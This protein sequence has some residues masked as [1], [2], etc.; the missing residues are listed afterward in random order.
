MK[1]A[2]PGARQPAIQQV[3]IEMV[4]GR[5]IGPERF[6]N[7]GDRL[8]AKNRGPGQ[9]LIQQQQIDADVRSDIKNDVTVGHRDAMPPVDALD[10][11]L[12]IEERRVISA[13]TKDVELV[14]KSISGSHAISVCH[15]AIIR[16]GRLGAPHYFQW[17]SRCRE[18]PPCRSRLAGCRWDSGTPRSAFPT[19]GAADGT[20]R[21]PAALLLLC[22]LS[23]GSHGY[24]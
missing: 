22:R 23:P 16:D 8:E 11:H 10:E 15:H 1:V 7:I 6:K 14:G 5:R 21:V 12:V 19:G 24:L 13:L 9:Q 18:R 4:V 2:E 3:Q 20:R 17:R